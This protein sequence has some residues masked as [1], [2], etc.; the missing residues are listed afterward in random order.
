MGFGVAA[1]GATTGAGSSCCCAAS[2]KSGNSSMVGSR[3]RYSGVT[4]GAR[5]DGSGGARLGGRASD[6][7]LLASGSFGPPDGDLGRT[8]E[9]GGGGGRPNGVAGGGPK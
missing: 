7:I 3:G 1:N 5:C 9:A 8:V 2:T 6:L 4:P